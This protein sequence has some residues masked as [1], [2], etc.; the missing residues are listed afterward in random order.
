M[1]LGKFSAVCCYDGVW[2]RIKTGSSWQPGMPPGYQFSKNAKFKRSYVSQINFS[3]VGLL[4]SFTL[5]VCYSIPN[6]VSQ[7]WVFQPC[8][9]A[10][11]W[12]FMFISIGLGV[13]REPQRLS[14]TKL[15]FIACTDTNY[16]LI[17][18]MTC[19][20]PFAELAALKSCGSSCSQDDSQ[21]YFTEDM[22][23]PGVFYA[24]SEDFDHMAL[25]E[26]RMPTPQKS[27]VVLC[28]WLLVITFR[29]SSD[30][31]LQ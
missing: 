1:C 13:A 12:D 29:R 26:I 8:R 28:M 9:Q 15:S 31:H 6:V 14:M 27:N 22:L 11:L 30:S 5:P 4:S 17:S 21:A 16:W 23:S 10:P 20:P 3:Y 19:Y 2:D 25:L 24:D 7:C 18:P